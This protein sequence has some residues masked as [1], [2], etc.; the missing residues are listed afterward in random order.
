MYKLLNGVQL[1]KICLRIAKIL[2]N[3]L[4][5]IEDRKKISAKVLSN[6][7]VIATINLF[8][9]VNTKFVNHIEI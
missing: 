1:K 3:F 8:I 9:K 4:Y 2:Y 5:S 6:K 7:L